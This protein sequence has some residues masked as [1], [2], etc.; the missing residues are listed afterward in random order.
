MREYISVV[1][2]YQLSYD[3]PGKRDLCTCHS[4]CLAYDSPPFPKPPLHSAF[5]DLSVHKAAEKKGDLQGIIHSA[6]SHVIPPC[7]VGLSSKDT[8]SRKPSL[9][10]YCSLCS[11]S[12]AGT[13]CSH[14]LFLTP[15]S[16]GH[17]SRARA[18]HSCSLWL[19]LCLKRVQAQ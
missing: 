9:C 10:S 13:V 8:S 17:F 7:P 1:L 19:Q 11:H 3:S 2:S 4:S 16:T 18:V 6:P 14:S 5:A 15:L 12:C